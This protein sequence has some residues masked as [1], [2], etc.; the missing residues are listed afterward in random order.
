MALP[1]CVTLSALQ[2]APEGTLCVTFWTAQTFSSTE[3]G[4]LHPVHSGKEA[5]CG[6]AIGPLSHFNLRFTT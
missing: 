3:T 1:H 5:A 6:P 4:G 2:G